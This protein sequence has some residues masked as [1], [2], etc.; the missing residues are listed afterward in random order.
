MLAQIRFE[1]RNSFWGDAEFTLQ[2]APYFGHD[3]GGPEW[4]IL[5]LA[6]CQPQQRISDWRLN[7]Y[8]GVDDRCLQGLLEL[9]SIRL[10]LL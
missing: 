9:T 6:F 7:Q 4:P 5:R 1:M 10:G 3:V 2:G 8:I